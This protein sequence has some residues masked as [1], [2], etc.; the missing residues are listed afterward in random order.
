MRSIRL[1][2]S[3]CP[4]ET[5]GQSRVLANGQHWLAAGVCLPFSLQR[6]RVWASTQTPA[7][8]EGHAMFETH[9]DVTEIG[10]QI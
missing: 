4:S 3:P 5:I 2:T 6:T 1:T 7:D 10:Q 8:L 9:S